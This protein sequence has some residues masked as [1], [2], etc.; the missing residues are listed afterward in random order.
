M[1]QAYSE[2]TSFAIVQ[3][4]II[5]PIKTSEVLENIFNHLS[6]FNHFIKRV[7]NTLLVS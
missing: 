7:S 5:L 3:I 4:T 1:V 2:Y 6:M